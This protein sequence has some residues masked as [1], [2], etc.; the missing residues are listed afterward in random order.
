[1]LAEALRG[2][3]A[4][5]A[6]HPEP[7]DQDIKF[8]T[9]TLN[10]RHA[11]YFSA[12][13]ARSIKERRDRAKALIDE[14]RGIMPLIVKDA[15]QQIIRVMFSPQRFC[16]RLGAARISKQPC[17]GARLASGGVAGQRA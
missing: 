6:S 1:M 12:Q 9:A 4:G 5:R 13:Q 8:L 2:P 10:N 15:E 14:L 16:R 3:K 7:R 11:F 17:P